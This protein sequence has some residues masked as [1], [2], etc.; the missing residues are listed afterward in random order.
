MSETKVLVEKLNYSI[1]EA[2]QASGLSV[3]KLY[4]L[5]CERKIPIQ[6]IGSRVLIPRREFEDW[7]K[8]FRVEAEK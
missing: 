2:A 8:T 7:L 6:K 5:S 4:K 3:S 1:Q